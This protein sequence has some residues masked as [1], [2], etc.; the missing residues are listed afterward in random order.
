MRNPIPRSEQTKQLYQMMQ[1]PQEVTTHISSFLIDCLRAVDAACYRAARLLQATWRG[2]ALR[3]A[4]QDPCQCH[5]VDRSFWREVLGTDVCP[6]C[7]AVW[8]EVP[9]VCR[10]CGRVTP[11]DC[12]CSSQPGTWDD[13]DL[14]D[15]PREDPQELAWP[16]YI[17][18]NA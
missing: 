15:S 9:D 2:H 12:T 13:Y 8:E 4:R 10:V 14:L 6:A 16:A 18:Q 11:R 3:N 5:R 1:L 17:P 7:A